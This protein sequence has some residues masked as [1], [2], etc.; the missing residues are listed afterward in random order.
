MP[1]PELFVFDKSRLPLRQRLRGMESGGRGNVFFYRGLT[2]CIASYLWW[3]NA[4]VSNKVPTAAAACM[5]LELKSKLI[6]E[7]FNHSGIRGRERWWEGVGVGIGRASVGEEW[8]GEGK[9]GDER[10]G[11]GS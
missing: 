6:K 10:L 7:I 8:G 4:A 9:R 11:E 5:M 3:S 1:D 2:P